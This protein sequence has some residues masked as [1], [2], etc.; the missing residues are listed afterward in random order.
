MSDNTDKRKILLID[1]DDISL[2]IAVGM[3]SDDYEVTTVKSGKDALFLLVHEYKPDLILLDI[4]MPEMDGWETFHKIKGISLL[5]HVPIAF[6][7]SINDPE[8]MQ[9]A[10][11]IGASD[12]ITKPYDYTLL[13]TRVG[14][15]LTA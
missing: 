6:L 11:E 15:I 8:G 13:Q 14:K 12:Y 4:L 7:T 3:L 10:Q 9:R 1:D 2:T 5:R